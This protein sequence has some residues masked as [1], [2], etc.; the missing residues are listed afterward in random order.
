LSFKTLTTAS[1]KHHKEMEFMKRRMFQTSKQR[2][3]PF[4]HAMLGIDRKFY[5]LEY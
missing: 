2:T 5:G 1:A 3:K 4:D